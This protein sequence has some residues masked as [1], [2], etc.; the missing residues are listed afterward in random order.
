MVMTLSLKLILLFST[1]YAIALIFG[2]FNKAIAVEVCDA[3][4]LNSS[5]IAWFKKLLLRLFSEQYL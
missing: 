5:T 3:T 1:G 2:L 4:G